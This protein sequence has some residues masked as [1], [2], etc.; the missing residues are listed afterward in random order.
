MS[1]VDDGGKSLKLVPNLLVVSPANEE[2]GRKILYAD[3]IDGT[4]NT[5]KSTA[6]SLS[7]QTWPRAQML[8]FCSARQSR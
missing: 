8:G 2:M 3:Q 7:C 4:T 5:F 6:E 1:L